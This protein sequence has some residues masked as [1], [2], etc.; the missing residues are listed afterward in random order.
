M[1]LF[2]HPLNLLRYLVVLR[3]NSSKVWMPRQFS[4]ELFLALGK[5]VAGRLSTG[6]AQAW[7]KAL[8]PLEEYNRTISELQ[9]RR[10]KITQKIPEVSWPIDAVILEYPGKTVYGEGELLFWELKLCGKDADHGFFLE[11]ILPALEALGYSAEREW[12]RQLKPWGHFD[13]Y[14][15]FV[16]RGLNWEPLISEGRL[17]LRYSPRPSQWMEG[18][19]PDA[20]FQSRFK[21][22]VWLTPF[23]LVGISGQ[24][25][26]LPPEPPLSPGA[27]QAPTAEMLLE[28]LFVRLKRFLPKRKAASAAIEDIFEKE[29]LDRYRTALLQARRIPPPAN[30]ISPVPAISPGSYIGRHYFYRLS[31]A[32]LRFLELASIVHLGRYLQLGCGTFFFTK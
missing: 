14:N 11:V 3:I 22:L 1:W 6:E 26:L 15:V 16:A 20:L 13:I 29:E 8:Q 19:T 5:M 28:A 12:E 18:L 9:R 23:D 30:E 7:R 32:I 24:S 4:A 2:K 10:K 25:G 17:D 31:P 21:R 27:A